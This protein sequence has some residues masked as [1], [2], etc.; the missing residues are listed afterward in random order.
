MIKINNNSIDPVLYQTILKR[1]QQMYFPANTMV[2][3]A[4]DTCKYLFLIEKGMLRNFYYDQK[5][6]DITHWFANEDTLVTIPPSFFKQ[7]ASPFGM[8]AI[9]DTSVRAISFYELEKSFQEFPI[10]ERLA[11]LFVTDVMIKLGE[12]IIDLQT[13]TAE[14]RYDQLLAIHP[15][16][17]QRA[18]LG[19][20]AGYLG[21]KQQSLSR[22]RALKNSRKA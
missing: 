18:K 20:I 14:Y 10:L 12:K 16:I 7:K 15:N 3:H 9:E 1:T 13:K 22:I 4:G 5:G 2:V 21:I 17:F 8:E 19:H 6:N 11:R